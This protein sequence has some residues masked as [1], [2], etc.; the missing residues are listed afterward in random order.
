MR[1]SPLLLLPAAV[2]ALAAAAAGGLAERQAHLLAALD[3]WGLERRPAVALHQ[4]QIPAV[5]AL[6]ATV[7]AANPHPD[8]LPLLGLYLEDHEPAVRE[9]VMLAAGRLGAAGLELARR[10]LA[11][12]SPAVRAAAAWAACHGGAAAWPALEAALAAEREPLVLEPLLANLWRL[13]AAPWTAAA[14]RHAA[15]ADPFLRRA[16]AFSLARS[17]EGAA[18]GAQRA[19]AADPEPVIRA[20]V[21]RAFGLGELAPEDLAALA[22]A[23]GDPD[24]RVRAAA[25]SALAARPPVALP[26]AAARAVAAAFGAP[27]LQLAAAALAAARA[28]PAAGTADELQ[29]VARGSEPWL[30]AEALAALAARAE[31]AAASLAAEWAAAPELWRRRA[32]ARVAAPLGAAAEARAAADPDPAVRLAWLEAL[33]PAAVA[34]R[35]ERLAALLAADPDPAVRAQALG[36]LRAAG[37]APPAAELLRFAA[38]WSGDRLPD[39]RAEALTAAFA[40]AADDAARE[41]AWR[42]ALADADPAVGALVAAAARGLGHQLALPRRQ[43]R[44]GPQWYV[45]L[46][47]WAAEPRWLDLHTSRGSCRIRLDLGN[48]PLTARE[49]WELAAAGFYDGLT[50]HRVVPNFVVQGGDP[51][52]D[53]WGG[54]GFALPDEPSLAPFDSWRVGIATSGPQTGGCQLFA[55]LLP[56]DHLTGHY[57]NLG[58]VVEGRAVLT[59]LAVGDRILK[60]EAVSGAAPPPLAAPPAAAAGRP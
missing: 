51:R 26:A 1:R 57:T 27:E 2:V 42:L 35:R 16:A 4:D 48:A 8:D 58:E 24:W 9:R 22:G 54:P 32:A 23:L 29:R 13:E 50:V 49:I 33:E 41:A 7:V 30:A 17:A 59:A 40:A 10:G 25:C 20:T 6:A 60:L 46:A 55:T 39:A 11:D 43:A 36:L 19:L 53:G 15:D 56:A 3:R 44:H 34:A 12:R 52:G 37:L 14:A 5:R 38:A 47:A 18:R 28:Q 31:P 21:L 45:E